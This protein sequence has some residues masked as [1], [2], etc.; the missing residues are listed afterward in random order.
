M[1][2][3]RCHLVVCSSADDWLDLHF[4]ISPLNSGLKVVILAMNSTA[5]P[6]LLRALCTLISTSR[7]VLLVIQ[8]LLLRSSLANVPMRSRTYI[9]SILLRNS[10][11][12]LLVLHV[13]LLLVE[14]I[15]SHLVCAA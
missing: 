12:V 4:F 2:L 10:L 3:L 7:C 15:T 13:R 8:I 9:A 14:V 1:N 5:V 11:P 6:P